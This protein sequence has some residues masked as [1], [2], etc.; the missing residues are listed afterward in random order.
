MVIMIKLGKRLE[1]PRLS[2][3]I[4]TLSSIIPRSNYMR[5]LSKSPTITLLRQTPKDPILS[6]LLIQDI[7][8][9]M[10]WAIFLQV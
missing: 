8:T 5:K 9:S 2:L 6:K 7:I 10:A 3:M 1:R 4:S